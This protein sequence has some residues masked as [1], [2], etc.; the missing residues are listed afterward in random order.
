MLNEGLHING[1]DGVVMLRSTESQIVFL[2]Q[3]GRALS[4]SS[5]S[6]NAPI[7]FDLTN[8]IEVLAEDIEEVGADRLLKG[9]NDVKDERRYMRIMEITKSPM[10]SNRHSKFG[11]VVAFIT[12]DKRQ[13][14]ES[15]T[16]AIVGIIGA[17]NRVIKTPNSTL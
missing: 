16:T 13:R 7:V 8:N 1:V 2:Q 12:S 10:L 4:V 9:A 5:N 3:L 14:S 11:V 17:R 6:E 15:P